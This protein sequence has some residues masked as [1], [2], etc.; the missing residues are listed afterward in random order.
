M[1]NIAVVN[2]QCLERLRRPQAFQLINTLKKSLNARVCMTEYRGHA[3][4]IA[5]EVKGSEIIISAGGD[6]TTFEIINAIDIARHKFAIVPIGAGNSLAHD[7]DIASLDK[8]LTVIKSGRTK[9]IDVAEAIFE[10]KDQNCRRYFLATA[11]IGFFADAAKTA[12]SYFKRFGRFCYPYAGLLHSFRRIALECEVSLDSLPSEHA[13]FTNLLINNTAHIGHMSVFKD[14]CLF[15]TKLNF[16]I[17]K[18]GIVRQMLWN[19]SVIRGSY[20]HP[21]G[22]NCLSKRIKISLAKP[23]CMMLDGEFFNSIVT[24]EFSVSDKKISI[25]Y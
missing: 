24:A 12:N 3:C 25:F 15:D 14:A 23:S 4:D 1:S 5:K 17:H 9:C 7:L 6:G 2:S 18:M 8:A 10:F 19:L 22:L 20:S 11:G 13:E 21:T 16:W